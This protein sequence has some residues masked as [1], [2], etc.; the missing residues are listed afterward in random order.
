MPYKDIYL[1]DFAILSLPL[2]RSGS[3]IYRNCHS[4]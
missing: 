1:H 4:T 3:E 2:V